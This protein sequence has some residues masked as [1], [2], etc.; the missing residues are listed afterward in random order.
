LANYAPQK[1]KISQI[2]S[3]NEPFKKFQKHLFEVFFFFKKKNVPCFMV[4]KKENL[5]A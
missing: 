4:F 1:G 2:Y 5:I 3:G